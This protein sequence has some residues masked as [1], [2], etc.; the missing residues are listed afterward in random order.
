MTERI[1]EPFELGEDFQHEVAV[2]RPDRV[3]DEGDEIRRV[4]SVPDCRSHECQIEQVRLDGGD[5]SDL[6]V[7]AIFEPDVD[8]MI[9]LLGVFLSEHSQLG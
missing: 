7:E 6:I 4:K 8:V 3:G 9:P 2:N 1:L 5:V